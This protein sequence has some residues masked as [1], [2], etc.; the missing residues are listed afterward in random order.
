MSKKK[1][2][3][4]ATKKLP[5]SLNILSLHKEESL[6][7]KEELKLQCDLITSKLSSFGIEG[8]ISSIKS[9][10][11]VDLFEYQLHTNIKVNKVAA[12]DND[13]A[14][15]LKTKSLRIIAPIPG[16]ST[17]GFEVAKKKSHA[18]FFSNLITKSD[19]KNFGQPLP[20]LIG[21]SQSG[22]SVI[23]SLTQMPHLLIAGST[24]SGKSVCMHSLICSLLFKHSPQEMRLIMIDPK[25]LEF[26]FY[27]DIPHLLFPILYE[28]ELAVKA[29]TWLVNEMKRRYEV[30]SAS[31]FRDLSSYNSAAKEKMP[32]LVVII[33][34]LA[35]LIMTSGKVA[36]HLLVRLAQMAR[37]CGI[38]L[39]VAT[40]R[41]SVDV[42]TG[43]IKVNFPTR[44]AFR[45]ST[46]VDSRVIIDDSG[47]EKLLGKGDMLFVHPSMSC[48]ERLT[49]PYIM[50]EEIETITNYLR[51]AQKVVYEKLVVD[52]DK[53]DLDLDD[54]DGRDALYQEVLDFL[55]GREEISIS[56]L[57]RKFKIGFNRAA[58]IID[59]LEED[60]IISPPLQGKMRKV[61]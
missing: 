56:L 17:I 59:C 40:Q 5:P 41:P 26:V 51:S 32:F 9:G 6:V 22:E 21:M 14:M 2:E 31:G 24:G 39:I 10:N 3:R 12:L 11:I 36:E 4:R 28:T 60:K 38:H 55:K 45:V 50:P 19:F 13:L 33:D 27:Q 49:G 7:N 30:L 23:F 18:L 61:L 8:E 47:A 52:S 15:I 53:A 46:K 48:S 20:L 34:E 42:V 35:D 37:A 1:K 58:R 16:K 43:L 54:S 29:L 44:I 25:R 57:Q